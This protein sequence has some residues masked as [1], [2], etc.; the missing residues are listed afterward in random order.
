MS[1]KTEEEHDHAKHNAEAHLESIV[2]MIKRLDHCRDC[3]GDEDCELTAQEIF[4]GLDRFYSE[5]DEA[6]EDDRLSYHTMEDAETDIQD[7]ILEVS[8]SGEGWH[9]PGEEIKPDTYRILLTTGGPGCQIKGDLDQFCQPE[10]A[11]I[12]Y[13]DWDIPW[14]PLRTDD[15]QKQYLLDYA[16]QFSYGL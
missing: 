11:E 5:G 15:A 9:Q 10:N 16:R 3:D 8:V 7:S 1:E 12:Q 4:A 14:T 6:T 13:Q 2:A